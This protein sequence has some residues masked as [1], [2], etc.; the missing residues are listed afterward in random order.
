[1]QRL[2]FRENAGRVTVRPSRIPDLSAFQWPMIWTLSAVG[3]AAFFSHEIASY[4]IGWNRHLVR[5][6][7]PAAA[8]LLWLGAWFIR[9]GFIAR[10]QVRAGPLVKTHWD[11]GCAGPIELPR[12]HLTLPRE[13]VVAFQVIRGQVADSSNS[14][15]WTMQIEQLTLV[16]AE[17]DGRLIRRLICSTQ[18]RFSPA[19]ITRLEV[20]VGVPVQ[21]CAVP[22][23]PP[24]FS[25]LRKHEAPDSFV[26]AEPAEP[27]SPTGGPRRVLA[28][29][30]CGYPVH[31][32]P[33]DR[34]PE[35]GTALR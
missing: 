20:A 5:F 25:T 13:R 16:Y 11:A 29:P 34:C 7:I 15:Q 22:G 2:R 12:W 24:V 31:D 6:G 33:G 27:P 9:A 17:D 30:K 21:M 8:A 14:R 10:R 28:C 18:P 19:A 26:F 32:L 4:A 23:P 1:M 3:A 35:C